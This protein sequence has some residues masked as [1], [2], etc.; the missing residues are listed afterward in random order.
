[1]KTL[2]LCLVILLAACA[3][4]TTNQRFYELTSNYAALQEVA[5]AYKLQ[6]DNGTLP[7]NCKAVVKDIKTVDKKANDVIQAARSNT[8]QPSYVAASHTA[9]TVLYGQFTKLLGGN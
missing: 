7:D 8:D 6:C 5:I 4:Q 1:M 9:L 3:G 2:S